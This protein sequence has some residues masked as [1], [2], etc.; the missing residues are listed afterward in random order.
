VDF[1]AA[2]K[3]G[4]AIIPLVVVAA[5]VAVGAREALDGA[6]VSAAGRLLAVPLVF[7]LVYV[8]LVVVALPALLRDVRRVLTRTSADGAAAES[9]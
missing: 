9:S 6:G 7:A 8:G 4:A 1:A 2:L 3:A 5:G